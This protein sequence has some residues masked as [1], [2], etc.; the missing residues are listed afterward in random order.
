MDLAPSQGCPSWEYDSDPTRRATHIQPRA[1][2][3]L[4]ETPALVNS[5]P[6]PIPKDTRPVHLELFEGLTPESCPY[7][8][9]HYR[10]EPYPCLRHYSVVIPSDPR[11]GFPS[12]EVAAAVGAAFWRAARSCPQ[13]VGCCSCANASRDPRTRAPRQYRRG[14]GCGVAGVSTNPSAVRERER[15]RCEV[16]GRRCDH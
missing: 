15:S 16:H 8:A 9:G 12:A 10:G 11:V 3:I 13:R 6:G 5:T 14:G 7:Y 2:K 1:Q 4:E